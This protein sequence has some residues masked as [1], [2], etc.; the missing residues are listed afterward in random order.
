MGRDKNENLQMLNVLRQAITEKT[1]K[2]I[3]I[4]QQWQETG[5]LL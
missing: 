1:W 5:G 2:Q 4:M 3:N